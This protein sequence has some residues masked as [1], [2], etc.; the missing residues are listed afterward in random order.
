MGSSAHEALKKI[1][2][3]KQLVADME[4]MNEKVYTTYLE[5]FHSL[6]I[7]YAPKSIFYGMEKM[8]AA[9]QLAALDHNNN[10]NRKQVNV[11]VLF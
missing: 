9:T 4:K 7:R 10:V 11:Y 8:V 2:T 5:V 6:K 1:V 3:Q